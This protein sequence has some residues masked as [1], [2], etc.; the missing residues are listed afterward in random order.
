M[1]NKIEEDEIFANVEPQISYYS[2]SL[3]CGVTAIFSKNEIKSYKKAGKLFGP[4]SPKNN[5]SLCN[6]IML[7]FIINKELIE[8]DSNN[9]K[10]NH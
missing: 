9:N 4:V 2:S 8:S 6:T 5:F 7:P 10:I 1:N 3:N